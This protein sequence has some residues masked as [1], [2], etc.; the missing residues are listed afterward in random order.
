MDHDRLDEFV[1]S[2]VNNSF[3]FCKILFM[4]FLIASRLMEIVTV[5]L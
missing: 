5:S 2:G 3:L 4:L 1:F